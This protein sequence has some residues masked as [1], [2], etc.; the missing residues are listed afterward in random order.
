VTNP[1]AST[2]PRGASGRPPG[3]SVRRQILQGFALIMG[4]SVLLFTYAIWETG[5]IWQATNRSL[6]VDHQT[7][8]ESLRLKAYVQQE[9]SGY[10]AYVVTGS[11]TG[12]ADLS[13][14]QRGFS[15]SADK[16]NGLLTGPENSHLVAILRDLRRQ[17]ESL[18]REVDRAVR[19]RKAGKVSEAA[20]SAG[21]LKVLQ[22]IFVTNL[23]KLAAQAQDSLNRRHSQTADDRQRAGAL[24]VGAALFGFLLAAALSVQLTE[25]ISRKLTGLASAAR[26][27]T[28]S[29]DFSGI[30]PVEA[31]GS[32]GRD[33]I[34]DLAAA[35]NQMLTSLQERDAQIRAQL[36]HL[37]RQSDE[38]AVT[39]HELARASKAKSEFLANMS[40]ELRTPLNAVIGFSEV[41]SD[42]VFGSL[43]DKQAKYVVNVLTSGRHL[44]QLINDI[45]DL[46]KVEAGRME[47]RAE[48][49]DVRQ[50]ITDIQVI[51]GPLAL[52][53]DL[54]LGVSVD[55]GC[56]VIVAD[57]VKF[58]QILYN[59]LS[60]A[61]KFTPPAGSITV[62]AAREAEFV[63]IRVSDTGIGIKEEDK[64]R[65]FAE[66]QQIDSSY[67]RQH[68]GTGLGLALT[69][70]FVEMH[71]GRI[72]FESEFGRG[73]T[74]A[75]VLPATPG[76]TED[77]DRFLAAR[78]PRR[79]PAPV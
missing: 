73:T 30:E 8:A 12:L 47:L 69:R 37:Q 51:V 33:E 22:D 60:N 42:Q 74:F 52:K 44:L 20:S 14:G 10:L 40:H 32:P 67:T 24:L 28:Q 72:W 21:E 53:K 6:T 71:G 65:I 45:L 77:T 35:F 46:S 56:G 13:D 50:A 9:I 7:V 31:P 55:P 15:T 4:V 43:N 18:L 63:E 26:A 66:F 17:N 62:T 5:R 27:I 3:G 79:A 36:D 2:A 54:G 48:E 16:L 68:A 59:L 70:K 64:H 61:V 34:A 25:G 78:A 57:Q 23:D 41:L 11:D 75:F 1:A 38:L 29:R 39:N 49:L 19:L 58:K 76:R